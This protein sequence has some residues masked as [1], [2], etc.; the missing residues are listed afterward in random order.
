MDSYDKEKIYELTVSFHVNLLKDLRMETFPVP[1]PPYKRKKVSREEKIGDV[2]RFQLKRLGEVL[3]ENGIE[4][5]SKTIQGDDLEAEDIIKI[6][7]NEDL[8]EQKYIG[9]GK[10][11]RRDRVKSSWIIENRREHQKRVSKA[12]SEIINRLYRKYLKDPIRNNKMISEILE[13]EETDEIKL[14]NSFAKQYGILLLD[15]KKGTELFNQLRTRVFNVLYKY[16]DEEEK[17]ELREILKK[18]NIQIQLND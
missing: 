8:R 12:Y 15:D 11:R 9:K 6:E 16:F 18:E 7:I 14:I 5:D 2:L 17:A 4:S 3:D 1:E 10:N 13:I